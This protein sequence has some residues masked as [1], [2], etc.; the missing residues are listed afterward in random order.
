MLND[1]NL[2]VMMYEADASKIFP[3]TDITGGVVITYRDKKKNYGRIGVFTNF[4]E[5]NSILQKVNSKS[6]NNISDIITGAVPYGF[7]E[8]MKQDHPEWVELAGKSFDLRTNHSI[9][10]KEKCSF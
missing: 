9:N 6:S 7:S 10:C 3:G 5:L 1:D 8:I 2:K 4:M